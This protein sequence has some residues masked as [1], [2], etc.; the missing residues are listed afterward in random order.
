ML[1]KKVFLAGE[2]NFSAPRARLTRADVRDHIELQ[3]IDDRKGIAHAVAEA[4]SA[5]I[6]V[7]AG[8]RWH[9]GTNSRSRRDM[10]PGG[11]SQCYRAGAVVRGGLPNMFAV[12]QAFPGSG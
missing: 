11:S 9:G 2:L 3:K 5:N 6:L 10:A 12:T 7:I 8:Y 4:P 1:S